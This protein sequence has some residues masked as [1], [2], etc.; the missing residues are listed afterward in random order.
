MR[1]EYITFKLANL[2]TQFDDYTKRFEIVS[3]ELAVS[4]K[5]IVF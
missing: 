4:K 5:A 1:I 3:S 2:A